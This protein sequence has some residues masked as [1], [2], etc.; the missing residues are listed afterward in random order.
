MNVNIPVQ[1]PRLT[2]AGAKPTAAQILQGQIAIN[3]T[4]KKFYTQDQSG[5]IQQ[6]GVALSDLSAV[7]VTG[8][9]NDL[10]NKP[11]A[12]NYTLPPASGAVLGG[13]KISTGLTVTGDGTLSANVASV[14][15]KT[16]A[17][18][19]VS[20]DVGIPTDLLSGAG[21]TLASKYAPSGTTGQLNFKGNWNAN[22]NTPALTSSVGTNGDFYIVSVAGTTTLNGISSWAVG[23]YVIFSS[24]SNAWFKN[25][26]GGAVTSVAGKTGAVT[27]VPGDITG[28]ATVASTG[29]YNDLTN[30]PT[31]YALPIATTAVLGGVLLT[32]AAQT[33]G[34]AASGKL[35]TVAV[36]GNY[37][38]LIGTPPSPSIARLPVN[39][40]G[41]PNII[42]EV[43]YMFTDPAQFP[44]NFAGSVVNATL[45][46]GT[47]ATVRIMQY[48]AANPNGIQV[49]TI[50]IDTVNGN[51]F[52][53]VG[54]TTTFVAGDR[55]SYQFATTNIG[56]ITATLKGTWT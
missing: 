6:I 40:Q 23:D 44:N 52:S 9:Y 12:G 17:V 18:T 30:K 27:L 8:N 39:V 4:D 22:T 21:G 7:A 49:G 43:F 37:S 41:N 16:G 42:N 5:V 45:T 19:L 31:A 46:S 54:P 48:N 24:T 55:F 15:G 32:T 28:L 3:L 56:L 13:V 29:S 14:A 2:T 26:N 53:S 1:H 34:N 51:S 20:T 50:S 25:A 33:A 11:T 47:T 38:D 35:A 10:T 36:T